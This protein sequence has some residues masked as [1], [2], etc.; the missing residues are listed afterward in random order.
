MIPLVILIV[1]V[2]VHFAFWGHPP[3]VVFDEVHAG[4]FMSNYWHGT[5][6][7]D[8]HPPLGKL[9]EAAFGLL[10]GANHAIADYATIGDPLPPSVTLLRLLPIIAGTLLPLIAYL[11]LR[12]LRFSKTSAFTAATLI[13]LENSLVVQSRF[14]LY[15][16]IMIACG[17][18]AFLAYQYYVE[19]P[20]GAPR[21]RWLCLVI[22]L[23]AAA[24]AP[25]IKW[26]GLA[27][28][29]L[30]ILFEAWRL[31]TG[32]PAAPA[33]QRFRHWLRLSLA[34]GAVTVVVYVGLFAV[35]F[36]LLPQAGPGDAFMSPQFLKTLSGTMEAGNQYLQAENFADKVIELNAAMYRADQSLTAPHE[37]S[38]K[39][40]T[41]P[42]ELRPIFYWQSPASS[43][44]ASYIYLLG[45]PVDYWL[46]SISVIALVIYGMLIVLKGRLKLLAPVQ[47][48][49]LFFII[50]G[51]LV[52]FL[53]F[54]FIGRVMFLYHYEAALVWSVMAVSFC[55]EI[56]P[57]R[58]RRVAAITL[59]S[60]A[61][62]AFIFFSPLTYGTPLTD[63]ALHARMW[64]PTW[65]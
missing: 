22:S 65:R 61:I 47:S 25:S 19:P 31:F 62:A 37:Y 43:T 29:L 7:F 30:I 50:A 58:R 39:W 18:L 17:L 60:L 40:Y 24:A 23:L 28:V 55:V 5:Y 13:T 64:L 32:S 11:V 52:N 57:A 51:F 63:S 56:L 3:A 53:P 15:D 20:A 1:S 14:I 8:V 21:V 45:N 44:P 33:M 48:R 4:N 46:G 2:I 12:K 49:S 54:I 16:V 59:V 41:W 27:F 6:F 34:Y 9:L 35:H 36:A 38:S 26:T 10:T 42:F